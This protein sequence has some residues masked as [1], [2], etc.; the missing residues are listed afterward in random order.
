MSILMP[1]CLYS[2]AS[3]SPTSAT[4]FASYS[5]DSLHH[6]FLSVTSFGQHNKTRPYWRSCS[7]F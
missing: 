7:M 2:A 3:S 4:N 5:A 6:I 1:C